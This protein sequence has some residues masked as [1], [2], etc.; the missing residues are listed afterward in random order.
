MNPVNFV[1]PVKGDLMKRILLVPFTV[2]LITTG[3]WVQGQGIGPGPRPPSNPLSWS[4]YTVKGEEFSVTLPAPPAMTTIKRLQTR[5]GK[6]RVERQLNVSEGGVLYIVD[7]FENPK[8]RQSLEEFIAEQGARSGYD[9]TTERNVTGNGFAGKEYSFG[10]K[11][12]S[13]TVQFLATERRLYRFSASGAGAEDA[14]VKQFFSSIVLSKKTEGIKVSDG[15]KLPLDVVTGEKMF[16]GKE[17][18]AKARL[19]KK[20]EPIYTEKARQKKITGTVVLMVVF[21]ATGEVT[22][23][24]VV[25]GLPHGLTERAIDAA[26]KIK[27]IPAIKDGKYVSMWIQLEYNFNLY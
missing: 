10:N 19:M 17:V 16:T 4:R 13:A 1:H 14:G 12:P 18:D 2:I 21:S 22:N 11:T 20:V 5:T 23:I 27:F 25:S 24:R 8:P 15:P 6:T 3:A 7:V 26:R 9:P